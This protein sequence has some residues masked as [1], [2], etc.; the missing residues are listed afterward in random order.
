M[1]KRTEEEY[2]ERELLNKISNR[3]SVVKNTIA[4]LN[5]FLKTAKTN[6]R[7][8]LEAKDVCNNDTFHYYNV[9]N[10]FV[11][12]RKNSTSAFDAYFLDKIKVTSQEK[13]DATKA[14]SFDLIVL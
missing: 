3:E 11:E 8:T 10:L 7:I 1:I 5:D 13:I 2:L 14:R 6:D 9:F 4:V 12:K